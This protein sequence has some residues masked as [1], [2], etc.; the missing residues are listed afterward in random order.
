[1][2]GP[3]TNHPLHLL[4]AK[5]TMAREPDWFMIKGAIVV[6]ALAI[7][8][9]YWFWVSLES[10]KFKPSFERTKKEVSKNDRTNV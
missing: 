6:F 7:L 2:I 3:T 9:Y 5:Y 8:L 1:M 4:P 10:G